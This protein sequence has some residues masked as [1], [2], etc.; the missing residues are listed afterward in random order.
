MTT[1]EFK[2]YLN[3]VNATI[4][5]VTTIKQC[6]IAE[7]KFSSNP[8]L[9]D[10]QYSR[11]MALFAEKYIDLT[12]TRNLEEGGKEMAEEKNIVAV[13]TPEEKPEVLKGEVVDAK[14]LKAVDAA[15]ARISARIDKIS[16][17][18]LSI[19][20]DVARLRDL[21]AWKITKHKSL[22]ELCAD[23]FGMARGTVCNLEKIFKRFGDKE[24]YQ[25]TAEAN[26]KSL[27]EMLAQIKTEE[28][29]AIEDKEGGDGEGNG[30][31]TGNG[32]K[33]KPETIINIEFEIIGGEWDTASIAEELKK[34]LDKAEADLTKDAK[35]V[36]TITR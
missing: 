20:G 23:K 29:A 27:R 35:V 3:E 4:N 25:L 28:Q 21:E 24:T 17:G 18:Y 6:G 14:T 36:L 5:K 16:Q 10:K 1:K 12:S 11:V 7:K 22:Y 34:A 33:A 26:G 9:T 32:G 15:I 31:G 2:N 8:E 13:A 19:V 30:E